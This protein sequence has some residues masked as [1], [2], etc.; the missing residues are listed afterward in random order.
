M[1]SSVK[2][3]ATTLVPIQ[4]HE[5]KKFVPMILIF[6]FVGFIYNILRNTKDA[7]LLTGQS[8]G[9]EII[10]FVK[11]WCVLPGALIMTAF[12]SWLSNKQSMER[13]FYI[14]VSFFIGYFLLF[15]FIIYPNAESFHLHTLGNAL[16][17]ILPRGA[18]G[19]ISMIRHWSLSLFYVMCELWSC[20]ILSILFWGFANET[21]T[22]KEATRFYA[23]FGVGINISG[24]A[25]G[26][27]CIFLS[28]LPMK[29]GS[30]AVDP[31]QQTLIYITLLITVSA[32]IMFAFFRWLHVNVLEGCKFYKVRKK[33]KFKLSLRKNFAYLAK[34]KYL[35][36]IAIVVLSFNL[37]INLVEVLWKHQLKQL[38]PSAN[39]LSIY[40]NQVTVLTAIVATLVA[41]FSSLLIN[42]LGWI[43]SAITTPLIL[44]LTSVGFFSCILFGG[45]F[46]GVLFT[47]L[48]VTP[49]ALSATLGSAQIVLS[50]ACK[51][52][53]FDAT[54]EL[55]F[56]PLSTESRKK[57]KA[58]IDGVGSRLGKSGGS[59]IHQGLLMVFASFAASA[60]VVGVFLI[61]V[62]M[63]W[64]GAV[65]V[66]G[67]EFNLLSKDQ[68]SP[69]IPEGEALV[70]QAI[71]PKVANQQAV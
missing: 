56:I 33:N 68:E 47:Y 4:R 39:D 16:E 21:T 7:L 28:R 66:L 51:Y 30:T 9:A 2:R 29:M 11:V 44:L 63:V 23:L 6:F 24:I 20:I 41:F 62:I 52:T 65:K 17:K 35:I 8:S 26:Q 55:A 64:M 32:I 59:I 13:V 43:R 12:F 38:Y 19:F 31:W 27:T 42:R 49:L 18:Y 5:L 70:Q 61:C 48:G 69:S 40:L 25:A 10:P 57:G 58:A 22:A 67:K 15:T 3:A 34:S 46:E 50:R 1:L 60:P 54:K 71:P 14:L 45:N 37:V 36:C 53:L